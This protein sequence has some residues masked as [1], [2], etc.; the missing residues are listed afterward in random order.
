MASVDVLQHR[1]M[2]DVLPT[3]CFREEDNRNGFVFYMRVLMKKAKAA[4]KQLADEGLA[5]RS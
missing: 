5:A 2:R 1:V 3:L 4:A